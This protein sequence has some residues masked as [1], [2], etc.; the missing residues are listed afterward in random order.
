[1]LPFKTV[2]QMHRGAGW[3]LSAIGR[4]TAEAVTSRVKEDLKPKEILSEDVWPAA[5][6]RNPYGGRWLK[7]L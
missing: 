6:F 7:L 1:M 3:V 5:S 4:Q 2:R